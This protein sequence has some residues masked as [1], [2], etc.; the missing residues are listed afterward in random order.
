MPTDLLAPIEHRRGRYRVSTDPAALD[1]AAI[2]A[3]L[4]SS[5]YWAAEIPFPLVRRS[6]EHSLCFGLYEG[7]SQVGLARVISDFATFAYLCDVYI[8]PEHRGHGLGVW[9]MECVTT[10]PALQG[11]RRFMLATRD[12]H[13]LYRR[14]GFT[15]PAA[16]QRIMEIVR[17]NLY[18]LA[19]RRSGPA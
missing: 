17:P 3:F 12:A 7:D 18:S 14:F 10:H 6:L 4:A 11:L 15:E 9:L 13:E 19:N 1:A 2:H 16:P 5:S 8:L